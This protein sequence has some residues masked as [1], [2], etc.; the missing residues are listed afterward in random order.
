MFWHKTKVRGNIFK[1]STVIPS[2]IDWSHT[3]AIVRLV[4]SAV[5][6][7]ALIVVM[8]DHVRLRR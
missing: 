4:L 3:E 8:A 6:G 5:F 2:E 1:L 7:L